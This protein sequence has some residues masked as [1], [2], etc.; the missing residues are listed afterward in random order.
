MFPP[1]VMEG[2]Q[3]CFHYFK[4]GAAKREIIHKLQQTTLKNNL[5]DVSGTQKKTYSPMKN[6][7][8]TGI[9]DPHENVT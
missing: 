7:Q 2:L 5:L 4:P 9:F 1:E 8:K 6:G 3:F